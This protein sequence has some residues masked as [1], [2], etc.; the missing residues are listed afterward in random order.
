MKFN[1]D[2]FLY[3]ESKNNK[4]QFAQCGT[5]FMFM[6][7]KKRCSIFNKNFEV[8]ANASCSLYVIGKPN[9]NQEIKNAVTP[10]SAGYVKGQVR[11]ENCTWF[12]SGN[13]CGFFKY[14]NDSMNDTFDI[15]EKVSP[16]GCC[17]AWQEK[18]K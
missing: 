16:Q 11:C 2:I 17:N 9:D 6:P 12:D 13:I 10:K 7:S 4:E 1:R 3:L 14:L 5:C 15:N 18:E 8:V